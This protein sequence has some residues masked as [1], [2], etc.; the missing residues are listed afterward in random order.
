MS[1]KT[2]VNGIKILRRSISADKAA[3]ARVRRLGV[4]IPFNSVAFTNID[5]LEKTIQVDKT[6]AARQIADELTNDSSQFN[7]QRLAH[8][9]NYIARI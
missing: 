2:I 9:L 5:S 8:M 3:I 4:D 7:I 1:A 6:I